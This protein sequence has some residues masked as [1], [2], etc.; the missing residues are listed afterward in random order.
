MRNFKAEFGMTVKDLKELI[1]NWPETDCYGEP[2]EVWITTGECLSSP[3][4]HAEVLN[5]RNEDGKEWADILFSP[6][7]DLFKETL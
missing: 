5:Y 7:D 2:C 4:S 6:A 3:V 1:K